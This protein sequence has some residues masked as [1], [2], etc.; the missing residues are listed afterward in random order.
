[1]RYNSFN[2]S[3]LQASIMQL[4][5]CH[6]SVFHAGIIGNGVR[7]YNDKLNDRNIPNTSKETATMSNTSK[8][9]ELLFG[10]IMACMV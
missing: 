5:Q 1:M 4:T 9:V 2:H 10:A 7:K 6:T 8:E 3:I